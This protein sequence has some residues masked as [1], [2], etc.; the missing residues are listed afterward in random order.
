MNFSNNVSKN[1]QVLFIY[2]KFS[3]LFFS[4]HMSEGRL[5]LVSVNYKDDKFNV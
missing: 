4:N 2:N 1:S 5:R 3:S